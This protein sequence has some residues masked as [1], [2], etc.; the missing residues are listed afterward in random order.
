MDPGTGPVKDGDEAEAAA[1][2]ARWAEAA[3]FRAGQLAVLRREAKVC[4]CMEWF[5]GTGEGEG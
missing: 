2:A 4:G 5:D 1:A 3:R